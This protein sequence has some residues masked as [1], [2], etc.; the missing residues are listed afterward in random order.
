MK[1]VAKQFLSRS[2]ET[3]YNFPDSSQPVRIVTA[4]DKFRKQCGR[5]RSSE[6]FQTG[7]EREKEDLKSDGML[8]ELKDADETN[9]AEEGERRTRLGTSA[10]HR[11][12]HIL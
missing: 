8:G 2:R 1:L 7:A 5:R 10:T 9:D 12:Q 3:S 11:Y 6:T 4:T